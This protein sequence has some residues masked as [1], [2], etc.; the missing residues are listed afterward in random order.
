VTDPS[1][2][3]AVG[4]LYRAA[5]I[6]MP[7]V[8]VAHAA[9]ERGFDSIVL[10]EHTHV[11]VSRETPFPMG[12]E[13]PDVYR[14]LLDPFVALAFVA[15]QTGLAIGTGV[16]LVA[17]HDPI[18]LAKTVATL[19]HMSNGRFSLGVGYGWNREELVNH[20]REFTQRRAIVRDHISVMQALWRDE[21]AEFTGEH[22]HLRPSWAWPKPV[23]RPSVPV[24]LGCLLNESNLHEIVTWADGWI[25]GGNDAGWLA[26]SL[27][28]LRDRWSAAGRDEAG[29]IIW[30]MQNVVDDV[31]LRA[32][33]DSFR[34]L[35]VA[36]VLIDIPTRSR[37]EI[38]PLL[39]RCRAVRSSAYS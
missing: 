5:D 32:Q 14:R 16:A 30:V 2:V 22:A 21:E 18:A 7:V 13:L 4:L 15:A 8:D 20:G 29:P 6:G 11:P 31:E 25:P 34:A 12:G 36:Q 26:Q 28:V 33:L 10:G 35:G 1:G 24:L 17:Q 19:D 27:H 3:P 37:D 23:Q 39:D 9:A 38:L